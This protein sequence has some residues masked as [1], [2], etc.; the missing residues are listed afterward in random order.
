MSSDRLNNELFL[1]YVPPDWE[2]KLEEIDS[3][4]RRAGHDYAEFFRQLRDEI[5]ETRGM[6]WLIEHQGT[7]L[8]GVVNAIRGQPP[9]KVSWSHHDA[10]ELARA[11][12]AERDELKARQ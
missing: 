5:E 3:I 10:P 4:L 8:R 9:E 7:L 2:Q 6:H 1:F 12:V 11:L